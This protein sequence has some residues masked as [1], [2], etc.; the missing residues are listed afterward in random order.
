MNDQI[1]KIEAELAEE[2][3]TDV[4]DEIKKVTGGDN[5]AS[6]DNAEQSGDRA[7]G[8]AESHAGHSHSNKPDKKVWHV[9]N[10]CPHWPCEGEP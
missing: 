5:D 8:P 1:K 7:N 3:G 10:E 2:L 4:D 6:K 9:R